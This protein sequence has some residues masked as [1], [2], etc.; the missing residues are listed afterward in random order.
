M[1]GG[2]VQCNS[3]FCRFT[4][5]NAKS[6]V[7]EAAL[8][9]SEDGTVVGGHIQKVYLGGAG[10]LFGRDVI[11]NENQVQFHEYSRKCL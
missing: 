3:R 5:K 10:K 7:V 9:N 4:G 1:G 11:G 6:A 2:C 8:A